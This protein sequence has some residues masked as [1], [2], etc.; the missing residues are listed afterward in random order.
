M[1][2]VVLARGSRPVAE[3][4]V[5]L[6]IE[7][8]S[9]S[10]GD[11]ALV[12]EAHARTD[13][14]GVFQFDN[15]SPGEKALFAILDQSPDHHFWMT[16]EEMQFELAEA[17]DRDVGV[18]LMDGADVE[19][20]T[21]FVDDEGRVLD[22]AEVLQQGAQQASLVVTNG[23]QSGRGY[24]SQ[25]C[26]RVGAEEPYVLHGLR[27]EVLLSLVNGSR[28]C[29]KSW[30]WKAGYEEDIK[31]D[32]SR[33]FDPFV[34]P[35]IVLDIPVQRVTS[36]ELRCFLPTGTTPQV[37]TN[38]SGQAVRKENRRSYGI[39]LEALD[40]SSFGGRVDL[41][42]GSYEVLLTTQFEDM[43]NFFFRGELGLPCRFPQE[44]PLELGVSLSGFLVD[45]AGQPLRSAAVR[46]GFAGTPL[47]EWWTTVWADEAGRFTLS[48]IPPG[49]EL[50]FERGT[51]SVRV[52]A[53][54]V[55]DVKIAVQG[56]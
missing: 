10:T 41:P 14:K 50:V 29:G 43:P 28:S 26:V 36:C 23:L 1:T 42:P 34:K 8:R 22:P 33:R 37:V 51:E 16:A 11:T 56:R 9:T 38:L 19:V 35:S 31:S 55:G 32:T 40:E 15:V 25:F 18:L 20:R 3:A 49:S 45:E 4:R 12:P 47:R 46:V 27:P 21:R 48:G 44:W 30:N 6:S 13:A 7:A 5:T 52:G 53:V 54:D 17:E 24:T 2:G 39:S